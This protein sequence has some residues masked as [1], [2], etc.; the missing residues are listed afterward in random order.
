MIKKAASYFIILF[1]ALLV[2]IGT[3][4]FLAPNKIAAGGISGIGIILK[5]V[6]PWMSLGLVMMSLESILLVIGSIV[7]GPVFAGK[8]VFCSFSISGL[9]II[10]ERLFPNMQPLSNDILVQLIF[11]ILISGIGMG[12]VFNQNAST[13]GTD[14]IAKIIN[15][16]FKLSIGKS[17]LVSDLTITLAATIVLGIDKGMYAILGVVISSTIIDKVIE[18]FTN[19]KQVTVVSSKCEEIRRFIVENLGRSATI[20]SAKGA[21]KSEPREVITT[22]LDIKGFLQ[23]K[24]FIKNVDKRAFVTVS[25]VHEV[26]G[27][28]FEELA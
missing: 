26:L 13:G 2:A 21:Y 25:E 24:E 9:I 28:G 12:L 10:L 4:F 22:V 18:G 19:Y 15:K 23:L 14:I 7:I 17:L 1:G 11:G 27:E 5:S 6:F 20:Y 8:T 3:Y 16:Y